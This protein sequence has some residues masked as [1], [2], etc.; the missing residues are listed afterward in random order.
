MCLKER[1]L[2]KKRER[3][4]GKNSELRS[5]KKEEK[6]LESIFL[7]VYRTNLALTGTPPNRGVTLNSIFL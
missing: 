7:W 5:P 3:L 1:Q 2:P 6:L 4:W